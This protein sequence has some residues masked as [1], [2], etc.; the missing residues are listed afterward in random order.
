MV[1]ANDALSLTEMMQRYRG[2]GGEFG[3]YTSAFST[4]YS[5]LAP[6]DSP[7]FSDFFA[8]IKHLCFDNELTK[9]LESERSIITREHDQDIST[10]QHHAI[11]CTMHENVFV[12]TPHARS[13]TALGTREGIQRISLKDIRD[14]H[15]TTYVP[16]N[17]SVVCVGGMSLGE[18]CAMLTRNGYADVKRKGMKR[19]YVAPLR[20]FEHP[21]T[22]RFEFPRIDTSASTQ[23]AQCSYERSV[24]QD[25]NTSGEAVEICTSMLHELLMIEL[26]EK[27]HLVYSTGANMHPWG[28]FHEVSCGAKAFKAVSLSQVEKCFDEVLFAAHTH[29][30]LFIKHRTNRVLEHRIHDSSLRKIFEVA[31]SELAQTGTIETIG[32][33]RK[34]AAATTFDDVRSV[35]RSLQGSRAV[36]SIYHH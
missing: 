19:Q 25:G 32:S 12:G 28:M 16:Q 20:T 26:R 27:R 15:R 21:L 34:Q 3:A 11:R 31:E 2:E 33:M 23:N 4:R 7:Q 13:L 14:F 17:M 22:T 9:H 30:D 29:E 36:T 1:C 24:M 35:V 6:C 10:P 5:F 8:H 18:V